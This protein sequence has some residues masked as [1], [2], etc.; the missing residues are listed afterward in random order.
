M[1]HKSQFWKI[2]RYDWFCAPGSHIC[3]FFSS[4]KLV[5]DRSYRQT[6]DVLL[7]TEV[8]VTDLHVN[9]TI[10]RAL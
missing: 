1:M 6:D 7:L 4:N 2:D 8:H 10:S 3:I 9:N 5:S